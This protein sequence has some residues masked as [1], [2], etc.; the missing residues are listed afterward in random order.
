MADLVEK[1]RRNKEQKV[2]A[3]CYIIKG[4]KVLL[5]HRVKEPFKGFL[6]P[7]GGKKEENEDIYECIQ[8]EIFEETG[9]KIKN[10]KL[11]VVTTEIGPQNY[12]WIL[13]IFTCSNLSGE[14]KESS[15]GKLEWK[16]I[17]NLP[18]ENM[19][20]IDKMMLPYVFDEKQYV[21]YLRYDENKECTIES[22]DEVDL[23]NNI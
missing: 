17:R 6:V 21:M 7:P 2:A 3:M 20:Q 23:E 10:P 8:R 16:Y 5:L 19:S 12:N 1:L 15:E 22:L 13:F 14:L 11:K 4:D 18:G 9:L